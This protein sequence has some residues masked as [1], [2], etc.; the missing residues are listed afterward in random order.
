MDGR[1]L[2]ALLAALVAVA[3]T[4]VVPARPAVAYDDPVPLR[5]APGSLVAAAGNIACPRTNE[6]FNNAEGTAV[7]CVMRRTSDMI[8]A[9]GTDVKAVLAVGDLQYEHGEWEDIEA[10]FDPTWG[11]LKDKIHPVPG[12]H[13]YTI[14]GAPDY[15]RYW[16][17]QAAPERKSNSSFELAAGTT[18]SAPP[19]RR[20]TAR[21]A[22]A[23]TS[24]SEA[25]SPTPHR[26]SASSP[27]GTTRSSRSASSAT[28]PTCRRWRGCSTTRAPTSRQRARPQLPALGPDHAGR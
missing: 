17:P 25:R 11:R 8:L 27:T 12:S 20:P 23:S 5:D 14:R 13:E 26:I 18:R 22:A 24:G 16:G 10:S 1:W 3:T 9:A 21:P 19:A 4:L 28:T 7:G 2:R 15:Y 6:N